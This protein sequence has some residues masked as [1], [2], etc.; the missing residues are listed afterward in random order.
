MK[1]LTALVV[2]LFLLT[3]VSVVLAR[4]GGRSGGSHSGGGHASGGH[5]KTYCSSCPRDHQGRIKRDS[6]ERQKF[7]KSKNLTHT[8]TGYQVDHIKPLSKG[9]EDKRS[10]MQLIPKNSEKEKNELK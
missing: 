5:P 7:L 8:P 10:N 4:S 2:V 3:P 6:A 1:T 9:G